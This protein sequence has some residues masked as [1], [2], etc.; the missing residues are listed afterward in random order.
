M[1]DRK[2]SLAI[3]FISVV[4]FLF[5]I[6]IG[7]EPVMEQFRF[8]GYPDEGTYWQLWRYITPVFVHFSLIHIGFNLLWWWILAPIVE[9]HHGHWALLRLFFLVG[10]LS[11]TAQFLVSNN[12]FG[13][14]SGVVYG[15]FG[16][17]WV[18]SKLDPESGIQ[19]PNAI[20]IQ[21]AI[22][23][24]LGFSGLLDGLIGPMANMAHLMGFVVG[25]L[26]ALSREATFSSQSR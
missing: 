5:T 25:L 2:L 24:I 11:N 19:V 4:F 6:T 8:P 18:V 14:L 7:I 13:G 1:L 3:V 26:M 17:V 22:W 10:L 21:I 9:A 20:M 12:G 16:Y 15:L 23:L